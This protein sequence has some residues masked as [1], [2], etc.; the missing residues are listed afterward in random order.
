MPPG[1]LHI[2][3]VT[4]NF[5]PQKG[6]HLVLDSITLTFKQNHTYALTGQSGAGKSTLIHLLAGI[7][8]PTSGTLF[9]NTIPINNQNQQY[10]EQYLN[11][12]VGL[13]LQRPYLIDELTPLENIMLPGLISNKSTSDCTERALELLDYIKL[14]EKRDAAVRSLSGGQQQRVA[15]ARALFN[16]P[17]FLIADEPTSNLDIT[18][19]K[20][21]VELLLECQKRWEMGIIVSTHHDYVA[22]QMQTRYHLHKGTVTITD[23]P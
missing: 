2:E 1:L 23:A 7:D 20:Q 6:T 8:T 10:K 11:K 14:T 4:K 19:G 21:M 9:F 15:L 3:N 12:T 22:S 17:T 18:T 13:L 5:L 16:E